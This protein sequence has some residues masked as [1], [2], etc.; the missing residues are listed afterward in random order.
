L[1]RARADVSVGE[2]AT[3]G[4]V[5]ERRRSS[6]AHVRAILDNTLD[7]VIALDGVGRVTFW[8][9]QAEQTFGIPREQAI[10][11]SL[12][13]MILP[14][15]ERAVF[16][17]IL[18]RLTGVEGEANLRLEMEARRAD[19]TTFPLELTIT[20]VPDGG[21]FS[22]SAF[23]RD[24]TQRK[25]DDRERERLLTDAERARTQAEAASRVKDEFLSTLSHELRTPLTAIVG[26]TYLLRGGRLDEA[27]ATRGLEAIERN[28]AAQAQVISDILDLSRM[29]GAMFRLN[30][31]TLQLAPVVAA[32]IE[33]LM[34]AATAKSLRIQTVL[35]PSAGLV[36]GDPDRLRQIVWN[37]V[38][39][40]V[41][42]TPRA[43]RITVR[44]ERDAPTGVRLVVEDT[45]EGIS[46]D[47][48]P[49]VF[50]RFRQGDSSNTRSH[51]GLGLGLAVARHLVE[52][53]GGT[54]DARS[55]GEGRG[56]TFTVTLPIVDPAQLPPAAPAPLLEPAQTT[57]L[58][59][60]APDLRGVRVLVVDDGED[61]REVV[62]AVLAHCGAEVQAV[63]TAGEALYAL[64]EF[65]PDVLVSE[66][67]MRGETG[68]SLI[69]KVRALPADRGGRVPAAALSAYSR[70]DDRVQALLAGFQIHVP[71]PIQPTELVA[72]VA[73][74]AARARD[75]SK[76]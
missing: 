58:M 12:A 21:D 38:S 8:N 5:D 69:Q 19:G 75:E 27:T 49:H 35:D 66:V 62:S 45:G 3:S 65:A 54:I 68:F 64:A 15:A 4:R 61:V 47:F 60:D 33:P 17:G 74:L 28:A 52:L 36:A 25:H 48:L 11:R 73:S 6:A 37:L 70:T 13:E 41:K 72:V 53:H 39:N 14:E 1:W 43:G 20:A 46:R 10:D 31:R 9:P 67:E 76:T 71:K 59:A 7:A 2:V 16:A 29:V 30:V 40:A 57:S 26:W 42:F 50:E 44:V 24:I 51:G 32:A 22:F 18:S 23:A 63:G 55:E 56:A 34:P